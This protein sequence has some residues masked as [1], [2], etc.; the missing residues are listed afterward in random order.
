MDKYFIN[1]L[2]ILGILSILFFSLLWT[3]LGKLDVISKIFLSLGTVTLTTAIVQTVTS[4]KP[5]LLSKIKDTVNSIDIKVKA[6]AE[7]NKPVSLESIKRGE[8]SNESYENYYQKAYSIN[9]SGI[10]LKDGLIK[11]LCMARECNNF[12]RLPV[13]HLFR[14]LR[15]KKIFVRAIL[16]H[17]HSEFVKKRKSFDDPTKD[18]KYIIDQL[19]Q[20]KTHLEEIR[21][22]I[23]GS[24]E[25]YMCKKVDLPFSLFHAAPSYFSE[26]NKKIKETCYIGLIPPNTVGNQGLSIRI[27]ACTDNEETGAAVSNSVSIF[28][29]M[30][31]NSKDYCIFSWVSGKAPVWKGFEFA[32]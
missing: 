7:E 12:D 4:L 23:Q 24:L 29:Y 30:I 10:S 21:E 11:H 1:T 8:L 27:H 20:L 5:S 25:I 16:M 28:E 19:G 6:M 22:H 18:I 9:I 32:S 26:A 2:I 15:T 17:P 14:Q 3:P 13:N 31:N